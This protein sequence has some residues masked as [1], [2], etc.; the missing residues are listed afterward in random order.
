MRARFL[1][2]LAVAILIATCLS[3]PTSARAEDDT[4]PFDKSEELAP[5]FNACMKQAK[6]LSKPDSNGVQT[7]NDYYHAMCNCYVVAHKYWNDIFETEYENIVNDKEKM[8][9][10][11]AGYCLLPRFRSA[12]EKYLSECCNVMG[13]D[14]GFGGDLFC[15]R[16]YAE[17]KKRVVKML[18]NHGIFEKPEENP[19]QETIMNTIT[20]QN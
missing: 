10:P 9:M 17:E 12:F 13:G 1:G 16:L 14:G 11:C 8:D 6:T 5:G 3:L 7:S 4:M 19:L 2:K 20:R 15:T 18:R